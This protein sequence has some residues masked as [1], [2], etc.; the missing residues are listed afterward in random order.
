[1][2]LRFRIIWIFLS[3]YWK[4]PLGILEQSVINLRV[5][6]NDVDITKISNDRYVALMDLGRIDYAF[7]VGLRKAMVK[8]QWGPLVTAHSIRF[9]YP[10]KIFQKYQLKTRNIWWDDNTFYFEQ[11]FERKGRVLATGYVAST[12][13][14]KEGSIP[15]I[16]ILEETAQKVPKPQEPEIITRLREIEKLVHETQKD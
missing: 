7:R 9:R 14:N 11:I 10:L 12:L 3:S 15:S 6:P 5:L 8:K 2:R 1:M 13:M 16:Q 4:K